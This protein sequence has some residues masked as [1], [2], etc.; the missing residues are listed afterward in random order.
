MPIN[1]ETLG[2]SRAPIVDVK[3]G[4]VR[5]DFLRYLQRLEQKTGPTLTRRGQI[6]A[7]APISTRTEG[8][9]T[10]VHRLTSAGLRTNADQVA[11][12]GATFA[13]VTL[14]QRTGGGRGFVA[15]DT[16]NRL[17][18]SF[19]ANPVNVSSTP[20]SATVLSND[21]VA[22]A[23]P[24]AA[25]TQQFGAGTV[26]YNSGSVDPGVFG[27]FFVYAD[28]PTFAG[29]A[30]TYVFTTTT[31]DQT[32]AEGRVYFGKITTSAGPATTGGGNTG[33]TT[34]G[35]KGGKGFEVL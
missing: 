14:D 7:T 15:L 30:V 17:A 31:P 8:I 1:P 2:W 21:G 20:T 18:N 25:S 10:T 9:S 29:G 19:R 28:D 13:R 35:G 4:V 6:E 34:T 3:T 22:T 12:D 32:A 23:I 27:T 16:N 11:A 5:P 24:I 33:G 26:S